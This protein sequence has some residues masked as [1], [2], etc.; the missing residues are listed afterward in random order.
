MTDA[1]FTVTACNAQEFN[2]ADSTKWSRIK[3]R[4]RRSIPN[5]YQPQQWDG[6][7]SAGRDQGAQRTDN[8]ARWKPMRT[9]S[10]GHAL[11]CLAG[12]GILSASL[13]IGVMGTARATASPIS[14]LANTAEQSQITKTIYPALLRQGAF[15]ELRPQHSDMC[16][17]VDG[18]GPGG[19][20]ADLANV[21][22]FHCTGNRN[23]H[24]RMVDVGNGF[25]ELRPQHVNMMCLDVDGRGPGGAGADLANVQQFHC[26]GN[27][28]QHWRMAPA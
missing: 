17:D 9:R 4:V 7:P 26:T 24:W 6:E 18:R 1:E 5:R 22:Q 25:F 19:V 16:L 13:S 27:P 21:Q 10:I 23:Q 8:N 3:D 28:N 12:T 2:R 15:F 11:A 14:T 20:G